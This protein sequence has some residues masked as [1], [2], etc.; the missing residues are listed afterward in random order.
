MVMELPPATR[1]SQHELHTIRLVF[2]G[3][4]FLD[5]APTDKQKIAA[6]VSFRTPL[7]SEHL[8]RVQEDPPTYARLMLIGSEFITTGQRIMTA[9]GLKQVVQVYR[10]VINSSAPD[11]ELMEPE[12]P[13]FEFRPCPECGGTGRVKPLAG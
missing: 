9:S 12:S 4:S 5:C 1:N 11:G 3:G 8:E 2:E 13:Q 6:E 10:W 7:L